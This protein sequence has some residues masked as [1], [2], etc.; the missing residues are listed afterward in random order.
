MLSSV[1]LIFSVKR[2]TVTIVS[3]LPT[4]TCPVPTVRYWCPVSAVVFEKRKNGWP[5]NPSTAIYVGCT[6]APVTDEPT[7]GELDTRTTYTVH[8]YACAVL[9][10]L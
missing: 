9:L 10:R 2:T 7:I 5:L 8:K 6:L 4:L 1:P 3:P